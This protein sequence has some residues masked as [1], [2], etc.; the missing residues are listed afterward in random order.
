[1]VLSILSYLEY[2]DSR[3]DTIAGEVIKPVFTRLSYRPRWPYDFLRALDYFHV[4]NAPRDR[5]LAEAIDIVPNRCVDAWFERCSLLQTRNGVR[6]GRCSR[7]SS[8]M[9]PLVF[10]HLSG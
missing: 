10:K 2:N 7:G 3:L 5:R 8:I 6:T 4:V 9:A 1:M